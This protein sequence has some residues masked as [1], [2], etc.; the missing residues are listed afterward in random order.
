MAGLDPAILVLLIGIP[1]IAIDNYYCC[2]WFRIS[3]SLFIPIR[4]RGV[5]QAKLD[6][7][8]GGAPRAGFAG[9]LPGDV[10]RRPPGSQWSPGW[11]LPSRRSDDVGAG[12][13]A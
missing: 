10:W 12:N 11:S 2:L 4:L 3:Y 7:N 6:V 5:L 8:G 13:T 9:L 1:S